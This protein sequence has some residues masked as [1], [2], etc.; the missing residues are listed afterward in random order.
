[1]TRISKYFEDSKQFPNAFSCNFFT[2]YYV[3]RNVG[4]LLQN[5]WTLYILHISLNTDYT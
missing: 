2:S 3:N 1:M 4:L 5:E